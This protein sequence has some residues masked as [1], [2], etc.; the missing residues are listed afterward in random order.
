MWRPMTVR[1]GVAGAGLVND[2]AVEHHHQTVGELE[3]LVE[4]FA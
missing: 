1:F 4:V 3:Q 2:F